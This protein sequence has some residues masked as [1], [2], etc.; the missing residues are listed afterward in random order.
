MSRIA[1]HGAAGRMG[2]RLI[3]LTLESN[4][5]TLAAAVERTGHELLG[6]DA[7]TLAG[8]AP[9]GVELRDDLAKEAQVLIDF[10]I[11][12]ATRAALDLCV[13]HGAAMVIGTTG[14]SN[15][16]HAAIDAAAQKI[17]VLQAPNMSL[18]VNLLFALAGQA[19]KQLGDDYDVEIVE[20]HHRFKVDAPSGT[21]LG[22]AQAICNS[23]GKD[24]AKDVVYDRHGPD[25]PRR[26]GQI[27][28][29]ALRLGDV[30]GR[31][32]ASFATL[33][34]ELQL[35]HIASNRDVFVRG[36]LR[37]AGWLAGKAAGRYGMAD[38]LGLEGG[39]K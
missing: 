31:H 25:V 15:E 20:A 38:V 2:R 29:H 28:M 32:T 4:D 14:L 37:A 23:T 26:R 10:S 22:I 34:E 3:A 39:S 30:V 21:A 16:D 1:I 24:V 7:G 13:R 5:L 12:L 17:A 27:G 18:G 11:P 19:A 36:A 6:Q 35:T 33:G 8:L 9:C